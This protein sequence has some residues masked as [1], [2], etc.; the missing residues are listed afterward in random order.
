MYFNYAQVKE[1]QK[2]ISNGEIDR[3]TKRANKRHSQNYFIP[4]EY[5]DNKNVL[6]AV[7]RIIQFYQTKRLE[8]NSLLFTIIINL[9]KKK[10]LITYSKDDLYSKNNLIKSE[11]EWWKK[12]IAKNYKL[13]NYKELLTIDIPEVDD[14][15]GLI[16]QSLI[17]EGSKTRAGSYYTPKKITE[18]II[19]EYV[20]PTSLILDPCCGTGQFL[21][22]ASKI[23][24]N[25]SNIWGFDI[26]E[27]A[28]R[29]ARMNLIIKFPEDDFIPNVYH[30]N[31]LLTLNKN[32]LFSG[33][34]IPR[35]DIVVTNP[36]WGVHLLK[37][38]IKEL[39]LVFPNIKSNETFSY[40]LKKG[41]SLLKEDGILSY[42]LPEAILNVKTHKD[43]RKIILNQTQIKKVKYL[44][45][46]FK[47]V[48]TPVI[49][50]DLKK[51]I[52]RGDEQIIS[53]NGT[54]H[55]V[56]QNRLKN[57]P[58]YL[59]DV[60]N[61]NKDIGIFNKVYGLTHTTLKDC[62]E[63]ALGIVTGN[64]RKHLSENKIKGYKPILTGKDIKRFLATKHKYYI[65]FNPENFQQVAPKN[66]YYAK[67]KLIYKFISNKLVF[68][69]DDRQTLTLNSANIL[70]PKVKN[71]PIK[72]ILALFNSSLYQFIY[73]KRFGSIKILRSD[74]EK[75][76][77]PLIKKV[78]HEEIIKKVDKLLN[79]KLT[80]E[81]RQQ[82]YKKLDKVIMDIF[83]LTTKEQIYISKN[84]IMK[85][86]TCGK[87]KGQGKWIS[88]SEGDGEAVE[89]WEC[90][91]CV[92][93][94]RDKYISKIDKK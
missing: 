4:D 75:L 55:K 15:L 35:F 91:E 74:L 65:K 86:D 48:F 39:Q 20:R 88:I 25:P 72:T 87:D 12:N 3:L 31:T 19:D 44:N 42:I 49:R 8:K 90:M 57:N 13:E 22:S 93:K 2:K 58:D 80:E 54:I 33:I 64:N 70:I 78:Q 30:K 32:D 6:Y 61:K 43:I 69:Y 29:I 47:N 94:R 67:E 34:R 45:R 85:C 60:F 28:V 46:L 52:P 36:P 92:W 56:R 89:I 82:N 66:K 7:Q 11:L 21:L 62:A 9:L 16:Y 71:Y 1:L 5:A 73:Q 59:F 50:L 83:R 40:F 37:S 27:V 18:D 53:E 41:I 17:T 68:S 77:L 23:I 38:D 26:D 84:V 81:I 24:D 76:P 10:N 14:V 63:W 79:I 51:R